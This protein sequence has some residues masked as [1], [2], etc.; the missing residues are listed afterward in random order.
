M[1]FRAACYVYF[2]TGTGGEKHTCDKISHTISTSLLK[3]SRSSRGAVLALALL[4]LSAR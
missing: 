2:K 4:E 3:L 1:A